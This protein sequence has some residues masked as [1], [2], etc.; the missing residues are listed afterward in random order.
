MFR[1]LY[2]PFFFIGS[3][4]VRK[5]D[6][7]KVWNAEKVCFVWVKKNN[8]AVFQIKGAISVTTNQN[9]VPQLLRSLSHKAYITTAIYPSSNTELVKVIKLLKQ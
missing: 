9:V 5:Y 6:A 3:V 7:R 1:K 2:C 4:A 8:L